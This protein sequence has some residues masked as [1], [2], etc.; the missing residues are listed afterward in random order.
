MIEVHLRSIFFILGYY[1]SKRSEFIDFGFIMKKIWIYLLISISFYYYIALNC[2]F[3]LLFRLFSNNDSIIN[4][5]F[6]CW[7]KKGIQAKRNDYITFY[8]TITLFCW[9]KKFV[10]FF[11]RMCWR[12]LHS[13]C[14]VFLFFVGRDDVVDW[15]LLNDKEWRFLFFIFCG[16]LKSEDFF[17][18]ISFVWEL[19][20]FNCSC[21]IPNH[22]FFF[23]VKWWIT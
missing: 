22:L 8:I 14:L 4:L 20:D 1:H 17:D 18:C 6:F 2:S 21:L 11:D 7:K 10:F 12:S 5:I 13:F 15:F 19:F 9:K 3:H 16:I 23:F